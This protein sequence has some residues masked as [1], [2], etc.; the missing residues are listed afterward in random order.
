MSVVP[1]E[2]SADE[3]QPAK[4]VWESNKMQQ[5][6]RRKQFSV[7]GTFSNKVEIVVVS[8]KVLGT[9]DAFT[10]TWREGDIS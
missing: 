10:Q 9:N 5:L 3:M 8:W 2:A 6:K 7:Y 4:K 1:L